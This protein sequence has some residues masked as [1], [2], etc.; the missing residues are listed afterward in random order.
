MEKYK[1]PTGPLISK[2]VENRVKHS[3]QWM[4]IWNALHDYQV[5]GPKGAQF[6][7]DMQKNYC[8][9]KLW[10]VSGIP[11]YHAATLWEKRFL[12]STWMVVIA[13]GFSLR[14]MRT[15]CIQLV[16]RIIGSHPS[17]LYWIHQLNLVS[18]KKPGEG[19]QLRGE[20]MVED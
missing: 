6:V 20:I 18:L 5:K 1:G 11:C 4:P 14:F 17:R 12:T 13:W 19:M 8:T 7:V 16:M 15:C 3:S 2:I 9:Y 10:E